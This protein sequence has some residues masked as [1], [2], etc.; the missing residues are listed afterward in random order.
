MS[1]ALENDLTETKAQLTLC[2]LKLD[3]LETKAQLD[4]IN[5]NIFVL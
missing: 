1:T 4:L 2:S 3:Q 5:D